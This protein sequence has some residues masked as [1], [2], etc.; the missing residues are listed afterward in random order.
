MVNYYKYLPFLDKGF[1]FGVFFCLSPSFTIPWWLIID[2]IK[3]RA[4]FISIEKD[5]PGTGEL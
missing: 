5:E 1:E 2:V 4:N 3:G